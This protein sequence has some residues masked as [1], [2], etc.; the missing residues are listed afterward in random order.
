MALSTRLTDEQVRALV[1]GYFEQGAHL[2]GWTLKARERVARVRDS[3]FNTAFLE[4]ATD[5]TLV[6][7]LT[8]F[9]KDVV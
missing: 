2:S 6:A 4:Q 9:Y 7:A 5:D 3:F 8:E 1:E